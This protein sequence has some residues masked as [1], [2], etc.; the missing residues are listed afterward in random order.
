MCSA[1]TEGFEPPTFRFVAGRSNPLSY[2]PAE[3]TIN[4][5]PILPFFSTSTTKWQ[6]LRDLNSHKQ[7]WSLSCYR[8]IKPLNL[9]PV[10]GL[11]P[12]T[13]SFGDCRSRR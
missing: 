2:A 6:G 8:Y 10:E 12:P 11:E 4:T 7:G 1:G 3:H 9:A 5:S 13:R